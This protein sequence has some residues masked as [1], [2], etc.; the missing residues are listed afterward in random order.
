MCNQEIYLKQ[1][2]E[3]LTIA[4]QDENYNFIVK[5]CMHLQSKLHQALTEIEPYHAKFE[6]KRNKVLEEFK[7]K[8]NGG[9]G[10]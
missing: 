4:E 3:L 1:I 8:R 5:D 9:L 10:L 7:T 6:E 2:N